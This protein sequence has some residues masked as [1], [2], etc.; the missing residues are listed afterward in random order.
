MAVVVLTSGGLSGGIAKHLRV[1]LPLL[2]ANGAV[3]D[4]RAFA[5]EA[6]RAAVEASGAAVVTWPCS[7]PLRRNRFLRQQ[8]AAFAPDVVFIP[9]ARWL[10]VGA[11][12]TV[13]MVRN[14][15]PLEVPFGGN[16][17]REKV[18]NVGR[19]LAALR[20]CKRAARVIAVSNHVRD[21]LTS[22]WS[23]GESKIAV[24]YHGVDERAHPVRPRTLDGI[25]GGRFLFTA[26]SIR[27]ARGLTDAVTALVHDST[28]AALPLVIAGKVDPGAERYKQRLDRMIAAGGVGRRI[29]W[30]GQLNANEMAWCFRNAAAFITTSRA[31][32]CPNTVLEAMSNGAVSISG[33]NAPMPEFFGDAAVYYRLGNGASLASAIAA[34]LSKSEAELSTVRGAAFRRAAD[35]TWQRTADRT[36]AELQKAIS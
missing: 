7:N 1:I 11:I 14:M 13:V 28:P 30:A 3:D 25:E 36:V 24:V 10:D 21:Y 23:I 34:I 5:P 29:A 27:P 33:D 19:R 9:T 26:G 35:F 20:A 18:T 6:A 2:R 15:E 22:R 4:I 12:P 31:E 8:I 17:I 32:A 16:S